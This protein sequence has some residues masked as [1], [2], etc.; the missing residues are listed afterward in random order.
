MKTDAVVSRPFTIKYNVDDLDTF[1]PKSATEVRRQVFILNPCRETLQE[2]G[3]TE[4]IYCSRD[5]SGGTQEVVC[6]R[7]GICGLDLVVE[8]EVV[9]VKAPEPP[10]IT[11]LGPKRIEINQYE[12]YKV[13]G[14][15]KLAGESCDDGAEA[16]GE[17]DGL[18]TAASNP[19]Q[20]FACGLKFA[21]DGVSGCKIDTQIAD[22][23]EISFYAMD[24]SGLQSETVT[25]KLVVIPSCPPGEVTCINT[26]CSVDGVCLEDVELET[27][28]DAEEEDEVADPPIATLKT[29]E[30]FGASIQL[31]QYNPYY[32]C[33]AD[34]IPTADVPCEPGVLVMQPQTGGADPKDISEFTLSCPPSDCLEYVPACP[35]HYFKSKGVVGCPINPNANPGTTFELEFIVF[36]QDAQYPRQV[37]VKRTIIIA[38][39]CPTGQNLCVVD[40]VRQCSELECDVLLMLSETVVQEDVTPPVI[41]LLGDV[42]YEVKYGETDETI[43]LNA[44]AP[45]SDRTNCLMYAIDEEDGDVSSS[46][47][48]SQNVDLSTGA[49]GINDV[50]RGSCI[51]GTYSYTYTAS[52]S[53]AN[54]ASIEII[55]KIVE[56]GKMNTTITVGPYYSLDSAN[57]AAEN[58]LKE[59]SNARAAIEAG[60]AQTLVESG[61]GSFEAS[62]VS[63][64]NTETTRSSRTTWSIYI[65]CEISIS[66]A[67]VS[68]DDAKGRR[69][70]SRILLEEESDASAIDG[71]LS[72]IE[73]SLTTAASSGTLGSSLEAASSAAGVESVPVSP[74]V[75]T[76]KVAVTKTVDLEAS[77]LAA[78]KA[79]VESISARL[80]VLSTSVRRVQNNIDNDI[81]FEGYLTF[82]EKAWDASMEASLEE[83][84]ELTAY[85][86]EA[87]RLLNA[88]VSVQE[89]NNEAL[90]TL[91]E[92]ASELKIALESTLET[93]NA[94]NS[95]ED[96]SSGEA[97]CE[98][99]NS[100][101]CP[102]R[103]KGEILVYF[104][105]TNTFTYIPDD[106]PASPPPPP[107]P[108]P[109]P[110]P[111]PV[112]LGCTP[113]YIMAHGGCASSKEQKSKGRRILRDLKYSETGSAN[114][115]INDESIAG[116]DS[117]KLYFGYDVKYKIKNDVK[118]EITYV[119]ERKIRGKN[120]LIGGVLI[121]QYRNERVSGFQ[122]SKRFPTLA[123]SCRDF[124]RPSVEPFGVDPIF[125]RSSS[126]F[127]GVDLEN[128]IG[129]YYNVSE[130]PVSGVPNGFRVRSSDLKKGKNGFAVYIDI[131]MSKKQAN[132][133]ISYMREGNFIDSLTKSIVVNIA[134]YNPV[135]LR[136]TNTRV[137]FEYSKGGSVEITSD[138]Q[139]LAVGIY[140]EFS[141]SILL[142][143]E[144][145]VLCCVIY[146][147]YAL[148]ADSVIA[149]RS[150]DFKVLKTLENNVVKIHSNMLEVINLCCQLAAFIIWWVF[151][152]LYAYRFSPSKRY[153]VYQSVTEP[154]AHFMM[155]FKNQTGNDIEGGVFIDGTNYK[156]PLRP[157][158]NWELVED[159][160][161]YEDLSLMYDNINMMSNLQI[162]Y[163]LITGVNLL[164]LFV[165][166]LLLLKFQP[167]LAIIT[168][169]FERSTVDI[170]HFLVVYMIFMAIAAVLGN[171]MF[172]HSIECVS[173]IPR[174]FELLF[175]LLIGAT[176]FTEFVPE[177]LLGNEFD[178]FFRIFYC[179]LI[180]V[181]F[182]WI[183][184]EFFVAILGDAFGEEKEILHDIEASGDTLPN[185]LR[186]LAEYKMATVRKEW[187]R[188]EEVHDLLKAGIK[189]HEKQ[190]PSNEDD[191]LE[192]LDRSDDIKEDDY[193]GN[194]EIV[195][196]VAKNFMKKDPFY[197]GGLKYQ[198]DSFV[199]TLLQNKPKFDDPHEELNQKREKIRSLKL[200]MYRKLQK[201]VDGVKG[202]VEI[203]LRHQRKLVQRS[204]NNAVRW[205]RIKEIAEDIEIALE[206]VTKE[207][208]DKQK[209]KAKVRELQA[210]RRKEEKEY[211]VKW[212]EA[213]EKV[214]RYR[215]APPK[216]VFD[217]TRVLLRS[218]SKSLKIQQALDM[219]K[220]YSQHGSKSSNRRHKEKQIE[221]ARNAEAELN[222]LASIKKRK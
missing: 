31:K 54:E 8:E 41:Y 45:D 167:R 179:G 199:A 33:D 104:N 117:E 158:Y 46:I 90:I 118:K 21:V 210:K 157:K 76:T 173:S 37:S 180:P 121:T 205:K 132:R 183:L 178:L 61:A 193:E 196:H 101:A 213:I 84:A 127:G 17:Y 20:I 24:S 116:G 89:S 161:G 65:T 57:V 12:V 151:Q 53:N 170:F 204:E 59:G 6:S 91:Q 145:I 220:L 112:P 71:A 185:D 214:K 109:P 111:P 184:F 156:L 135:T 26:P 168:K 38:E 169:T 25:R 110:S 72:A 18:I 64:V 186:K 97:L 70:R 154:K 92:R 215:S 143:M 138:T 75:T 56:L 48:S 32:K 150:S 13:C 194:L 177:G 189:L 162:I 43:F 209:V 102:K 10:N 85:A 39:P 86:S 22:T 136:F 211:E 153:D 107:P 94:M 133:M 28:F 197:V 198:P 93:L 27:F 128:N 122:C 120:T 96:G 44:C 62:D 163:N 152:A 49:C 81:D 19:D 140:D 3:V 119:P 182:Q 95:G 200:D 4:E 30:G 14:A 139:A 63:V 9:V 103:D 36:E 148:I 1:N 34:Q 181:M 190:H 130:L 83:H 80:S 73:A 192:V 98:K 221:E 155:P 50:T 106:F 42:S 165:R 212:K 2:D 79:T 5:D 51:P 7:N 23:Y 47:L 195:T 164:M 58:Y 35:A 202:D 222:A 100:C 129:K 60:L 126:L 69:R 201:C 134:A 99:T 66:T 68:S 105:A 175:L 40:G 115:V 174:A 160:R 216:S 176:S 11:L 88:T 219:Q 16:I 159:T 146:S 142:A 218:K 114:N 166:F 171:T 149:S 206:D 87:F 67:K 55:I 74:E 172:G 113:E 207:T 141:G 123:A 191:Y 188:F 208:F 29:Y 15:V 144:V 77:K 187:P 108:S 147:T 131:M 52:D 82:N 78:V 217:V 124:N 137:H 203:H 125:S